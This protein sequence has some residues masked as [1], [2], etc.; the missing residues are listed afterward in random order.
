MSPAF[1]K[2]GMRFLQAA[3]IT[4]LVA[5]AAAGALA[6]G[7]HW[8]LQ[9]EKRDDLASR[10]QLGEAQARLDAAKRERDDLRAS[11]EVFQ[12]LVDRGILQEESRLDLIERL[13]GL[14]TRHRLL[15]LEYE[16][17]PQRPL[18]L[19]GGRVFNAVDV[20]G[21]RVKVKALALHEGDA[22]SFLDELSRPTR[23]FNP[24]NRCTLQKVEPGAPDAITARVTAECIVE[25]ISL[26]DK[27]G[28]RAS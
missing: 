20:L 23:G 2:Q 16:I 26:R 28:N 4:L 27:R 9:K 1:S 3:W 8:Y 12:D 22:L 21:S 5:V 11:S 7:S 19:A 17:A 15:G 13:D 10:R 24:V 25:W 6:W 14:K 18:Q